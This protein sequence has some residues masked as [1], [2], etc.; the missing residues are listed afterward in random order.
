MAEQMVFMTGGTFS[1]RSREFVGRVA[2]A[3]IDKPID[4]GRLRSL[5]A[6]A[7]RQR[8]LYQRRA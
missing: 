7:M 8:P 2:N 5:L 3:C 6:S 4:L 1:E